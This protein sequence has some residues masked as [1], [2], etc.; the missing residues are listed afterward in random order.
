MKILSLLPWNSSVLGLCRGCGALNTLSRS[1]VRWGRSPG[2]HR[3]CCVN[4]NS[5]VM[6]STTCTKAR[7]LSGSDGL[8]LFSFS[9][10]VFSTFIWG[11]EDLLSVNLKTA[12]SWSARQRVAFVSSFAALLSVFCRGSLARLLGCSCECCFICRERARLNAAF[13]CFVFHR[14]V[15]CLTPALTF[16]KKNPLNFRP[17][18]LCC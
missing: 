12:P 16:L 10:F 2:A 3:L 4:T 1:K 15:F 17:W 5:R 8:P 6:R 11:S 18:H 14:D 7:A 9:I 13:I